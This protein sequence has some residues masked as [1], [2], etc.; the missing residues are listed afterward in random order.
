VLILRPILP[1]SDHLVPLLLTLAG[2]T[3]LSVAAAL[4]TTS[5]PRDWVWRR[6]RAR[7]GT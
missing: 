7:A 4:A 2:V 6:L 1:V 5:Y 3:T